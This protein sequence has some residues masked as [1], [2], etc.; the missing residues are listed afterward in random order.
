MKKPTTEWTVIISVCI[1]ILLILGVY[2]LNKHMENKDYCLY[3]SKW[4]IVSDGTW[5]RIKDAKGEYLYELYSVDTW[6]WYKEPLEMA[7]EDNRF[8]AIRYQD[9]E[10]KKGRSSKDIEK[11]EEY[12][13]FVKLSLTTQKAIDDQK[14][15]NKEEYEKNKEPRQYSSLKDAVR[16]ANSY[17]EIN[18][19]VEYGKFEKVCCD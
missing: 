15:A 12:Q 11:D 14:R 9:V 18:N 4:S 6:T 17:I 1:T 13:K 3:N 2:Q 19:E 5:Y 16:E 10:Q 8:A 7:L